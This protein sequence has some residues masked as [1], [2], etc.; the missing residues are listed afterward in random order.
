MPLTSARIAVASLLLASASARAEDATRLRLQASGW[1]Q[2]G[3]IMHSSDTLNPLYNYNGNWN[4]NYGAQFTV[5]ADID[6]HLQGALGLGGYQV[7]TPQGAVKATSQSAFVFVPYITQARFTYSDGDPEAQS[8]RIDAGFFPF[9]PTTLNRNLGGYLLRGP[10]YPGILFSEFEAKSLDTTVANILGA[11]VRHGVGNVF[12]H[13]LIMR[14]EIEFPPVFDL[15]F[16]YL[17]TVRPAPALELG[18]GVNFYRALAMRPRATDLDKR[19]FQIEDPSDGLPGL[20]QA[21]PYLGNYAYIR[22]RQPDPA[23]PDSIVKD[24]IML[25]HRGIKLMGRFAFDPK[26]L[27]GLEGWKPMDL[28]L[29]GEAAIIGVKDYPGVYPRIMERIPLMAGFGIPTL[30]LLDECVLEAEYYPAP[31]RDDYRRIMTE[32]S[33][34]PMNNN[35][36]EPKRAEGQ[37]GDVHNMRS[38][39]YKWSL[40]VS[41]TFGGCLKLSLQA[42]ND[43]FR[44]LTHLNAEPTLVERLESASTTQKDWY[45]MFRIGYAFQ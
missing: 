44:P 34:I 10:V 1:L 29:Y 45:L 40:Y 9:Q 2:F 13:D 3:R 21:N 5:A 6:A 22:R 27:L 30:G 25:S 14:S 18:A 4:E 41:R 16:I 19:D 26:P 38:D 15:S 39:D 33:P 12:T 36:Y 20:A 23:K 17:A 31:F 35:S 42:A 43:H 28:K 11:H 8:L 37:A 24:T 7:N 32:A